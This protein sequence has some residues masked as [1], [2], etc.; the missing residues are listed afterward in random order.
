[1][2]FFSNKEPREFYL[3]YF[4]LV[5][6]TKTYLKKIGRIYK[7]RGYNVHFYNANAENVVLNVNKQLSG[8]KIY[9]KKVN[10]LEETICLFVTV[11]KRLVVKSN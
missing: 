8:E 6:V 5:P 4:K 7:V 1:M 9:F 10:Y 11:W 3:F 2:S